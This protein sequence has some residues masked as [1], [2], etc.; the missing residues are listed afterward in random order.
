MMSLST[1]ISYQITHLKSEA[2]SEPFGAM[3]LFAKT[4]NN[5]QLLTIFTKGIS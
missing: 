2:Y 4:V 3:E 5:F 1:S